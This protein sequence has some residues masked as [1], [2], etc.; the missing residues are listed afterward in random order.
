MRTSAFA[1]LGLS[2]ALL[3][4][5]GCSGDG[6]GPGD[7][8]TTAS[9][10]S[11]SQGPS[12]TGSGTPTS[13]GTTVASADTTSSPGDEGPATFGV[14]D[15][16]RPPEYCPPGVEPSLT[17]GHGVEEFMPA[18]SGPAQVYLGHQ[19]GYHVT[20]GMRGEGLDLADW[21]EGQVRATVGGQVVADHPTVIPMTC[22]AG[23]QFSEALWINL[24]FEE[25]PTP[26]LGQVASVEAEYVDASAHTVSGTVELTLSDEIVPL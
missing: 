19:G 5:A 21:G 3:G 2:V 16:G 12:E 14:E 11:T 22:D 4:T 25:D 6:G 8:P 9:P 26:L 20:L 15:S 24:V 17:I 1:R 7:E 10:T 18:D 23:G 13:G